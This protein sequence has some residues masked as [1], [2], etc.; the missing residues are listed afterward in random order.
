MFVPTKAKLRFAEKL[1][2]EGERENVRWLVQGALYANLGVVRVDLASGSGSSSG[3]MSSS[4]SEKGKK[5]SE[6][7]CGE[8][9]MGENV[10]GEVVESPVDR[11]GREVWES[12]EGD[13]K[14]WDEEE[15]ER[16]RDLDHDQGRMKVKVDEE[17][18]ER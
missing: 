3:S 18:K 12:M 13:V 8:K 4:T 5:A 2:D 6:K 11:L 7:D 9:K 10:S 16:E 17:K 15:R 14:I 1:E